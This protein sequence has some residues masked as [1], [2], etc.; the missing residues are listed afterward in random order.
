MLD[1]PVA[2]E[3]RRQLANTVCIVLAFCAVRGLLEA[4]WVYT[5]RQVSWLSAVTW[6]LPSWVLLAP[7]AALTVVLARRFPFERRNRTQSVVVHVV[8]CVAFALA[9]LLAITPVRVLLSAEPMTYERLSHA[10]LVAFRLLFILDVLTYWAI[11]GMY[12]RASL[13]EP[14][15][16]PGRSASG[17]AA[18]AAQSS[19][20]VQRVE[21]HFDAWRS[22]AIKRR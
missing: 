18:R 8:A 4:C 13:L 19:F 20:P 14:S 5:T 16:E 6:T 9:H 12:L 1:D 2:S 17:R 21:R 7:L 10:F 15:D 22:K 3:R 11:V